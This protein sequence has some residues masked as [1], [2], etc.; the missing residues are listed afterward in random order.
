MGL[1]K[2]ENTLIRKVT[3]LPVNH[4]LSRSLMQ[5]EFQNFWKSNE[6]FVNKKCFQNCQDH[7]NSNQVGDGSKNEDTFTLPISYVFCTEITYKLECGIF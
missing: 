6:V 5:L 1:A 2:G 3:K 4:W 7:Q